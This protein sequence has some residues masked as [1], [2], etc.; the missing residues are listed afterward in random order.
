MLTN[1]GATLGIPKICKFPTT[2]NDGIAA[3]L[4]LSDALNK[5]YLFYFLKSKSSWF[6]AEAARGQGQP[7]LNTDI[8]GNTIIALPPTSEQ[9]II[10][11]RVEKLLSMVD[12]LENLVSERKEKSEQL[13]QA[14][15]REAFE[16]G[17]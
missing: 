11:D 7:N 12:E 16:G 15:L 3:F 2:F 9:Q 6:L 8:I 5:I 4:G 10:S 1:S 13:M 14:V 17:K